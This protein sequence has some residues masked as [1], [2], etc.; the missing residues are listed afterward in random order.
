[1][2]NAMTR[3]LLHSLIT[4]PPGVPWYGFA[5]FTSELRDPDFCKALK[6]S[7]CT[8]LKLGLE[9]GD[10]DVLDSLEKNI[11]LDEASQSLQTL[12]QVGIGTYVYLLFGT[13]GEDQAAA[14]KTQDFV[15]RHTPWIDFLNVAIFNLPLF[16]EEAEE[17]KTFPFY[18]GDL[19]LYTQFHHPRGWDRGKVR[20]FLDKGFKRHSAIVPILRRDPLGFTSNHA[21]LF[22]LKGKNFPGAC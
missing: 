18:E 11:R 12:H 15:I 22:L 13:P 14:E 4:H 17:Y 8:M 7:G 2:D 9:S 16:S 5:R 6:R 3:D 1:M 20:Q 10:Q 19:S 21:P